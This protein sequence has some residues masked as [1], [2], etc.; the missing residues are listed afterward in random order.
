MM[1]K[2]TQPKHTC[3]FCSNKNEKSKHKV[4][5]CRDC[6]KIRNHIREYGIKNI[7]EFIQ[8]KV[9]APPY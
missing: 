6:E 8:P 9:S 7:L 1:F 5:L 4:F 3:V 2:K